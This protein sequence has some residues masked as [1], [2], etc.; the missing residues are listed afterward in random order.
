[1][2]FGA[3]LSLLGTI[4]GSSQFRSILQFLQVK[5]AIICQQNYLQHINKLGVYRKAHLSSFEFIA[6]TTGL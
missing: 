1:M 5:A 4:I 3:Q 2:L 6:C